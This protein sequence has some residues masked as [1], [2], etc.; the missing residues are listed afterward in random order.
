MAEEPKASRREVV[1][2]LAAGGATLW[3]GCTGGGPEVVPP[4]GG[5]GSGGVAEDRIA[6]AEPN[7]HLDSNL[8]DC[9]VTTSDIEGPYYLEG[10]PI[11]TELDLYG[12]EGQK[13]LLTG[14]VL[15]TNCIP[16]ADAVIDFW[17]A[18]PAADYDNDSAEMRYRGQQA[19]AA[20]G[21][22]ALTTL[23]PGW[24]L[25]GSKYRPS[26]IH[27]KVFVGG[28]AVLTTQLYFESDPYIVDDPWAGSPS[29]E[30]RILQLDAEV[31][32]VE[33]YSFD[34]VV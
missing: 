25:N 13:M 26:H 11:R 6:Q 21:S 18:S 27:V 22:F 9:E 7:P 2:G 32:G 4:P 31:E 12:D 1:L 10:V 3:V 20:D 8:R 24:Y 5:G 16:I 19:A 34:L 17:Q 30:D 29:A 33:H 14:R 23:K 28:E 15:D